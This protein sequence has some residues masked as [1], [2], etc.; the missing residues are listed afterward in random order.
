MMPKEVLKSFLPY[1]RQLDAT[2]ICLI[3]LKFS[4][5]K[6]KKIKPKFIKIKFNQ[7]VVLQQSRNHYSC[8]VDCRFLSSC[9]RLCIGFENLKNY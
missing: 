6:Q 2:Y 5:I 8:V 1:I 7:L 9:I 4:N 3:S